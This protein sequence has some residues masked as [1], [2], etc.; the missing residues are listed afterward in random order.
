VDAGFLRHPQ[1]PAKRVGRLAEPL[2]AQQADPFGQHHLG[3]SLGILPLPLQF[4]VHHRFGDRPGGRTGPHVQADG[5]RLFVPQFQAGL[6]DPPRFAD[7]VGQFSQTVQG[8][9]DLVPCDVHFPVVA[10]LFEQPYGPAA[11]VHA[12][13]VPRCGVKHHAVV[14]Q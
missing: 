6:V 5:G 14:V 12:F 2:P 3:I 4:R 11:L 1:R 7:G 9:R 10:G 13:P 8:G